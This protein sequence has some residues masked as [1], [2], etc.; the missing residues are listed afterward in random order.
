M[1]VLLLNPPGKK[2]YVRDYYCSKVS[3]SNYILHPVDLTIQS[4]ILSE[5]YDIA[6]IDAIADKLSPEECL[7]KIL[8]IKPGAIFFLSG[9]I[10]YEEDMPF[11]KEVKEKLR[12]VKLIVSGDLFMED[13]VKHMEKHKIIDAAMLDFTNQDIIHFLEN[14]K[15]KIEFLVYRDGDKIIKPEINRNK[16]RNY[17][18]PIPK[19]ELFPNEKYR[20]PFVKKYPMAT[21]LSDYGCPYT[22]TF[23]IMATI[24]FKLRSV[25]K[26]IEELK[27][28]KDLGTKEV[29]FID[30]TFAVNRPRA[31]ELLNKMID[32]NLDLGWSCFSRVDVVNEEILSLM[33]KAGCHTIMFGVESGSQEILNNVDKRT[34]LDIIKRTFNLCRRLGIKTLG[35]FILGLPG[36]TEETINQ[37]IKFAKSIE[38]DYVAFNVAIPRMNTALRREALNK[39]LI[40]DDLDVM[41]QSGT[42]AVMGTGELTVERVIELKRKA[43]KQ[44]YFRPSYVVNRLVNIETFAEFKS[45]VKDAIAIVQNM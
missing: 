29:F 4:G 10:S 3:K 17:E 31:K 32:E 34:T 18:I 12:D 40:S 25:D 35:T 41:D 45:N 13:P 1:K 24:G 36:E 7:N 14:E 39:K 15:D 8:E 22:C 43:V 28:L 27:Y 16:Y 23:C 2:V 11:M 9:S 38:P 33:K 20:F 6:V 37:T 19:Y 5:K 30:Q 44:F 21:L 26:V 42:Y